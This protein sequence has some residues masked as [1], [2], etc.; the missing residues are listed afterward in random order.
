MRIYNENGKPIGLKEIAEFFIE[1]YPDDIFI[2][3]PEEIVAIR[4]NFKK[5]LKKFKGI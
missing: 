4:E 2:N 1:T 3:Q 5:L